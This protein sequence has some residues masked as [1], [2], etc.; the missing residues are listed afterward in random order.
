MLMI[1][2]W[3][4][5]LCKIA[6]D[7]GYRPKFARKKYKLRYQPLLIYFIGEL[8]YTYVQLSL[9]TIATGPLLPVIILVRFIEVNL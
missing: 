4:D 1:V 8:F 3:R 2:V 9:D 7:V 6:G 5:M